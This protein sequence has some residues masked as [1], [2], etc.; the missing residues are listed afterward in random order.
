MPI[1]CFDVNRVGDEKLVPITRHNDDS[2]VPDKRVIPLELVVA[3]PENGTSLLKNPFEEVFSARK[4][5]L[6]SVTD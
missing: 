1:F 2:I 6:S 3:S 5:P 4:G